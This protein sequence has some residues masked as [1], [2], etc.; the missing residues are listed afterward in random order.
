MTI[1]RNYSEI[2]LDI[3]ESISGGFDTQSAAARLFLQRSM[4]DAKPQGETFEQFVLR[5]YKILRIENL[6]S[7]YLP[8]LRGI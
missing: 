4:R 5:F 1:A 6:G 7:E 8:K 2:S 3:L